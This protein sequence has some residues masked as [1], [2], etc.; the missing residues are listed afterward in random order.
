MGEGQRP[1]PRTLGV[2]VGGLGTIGAVVAQRLDA[3]I[4]GLR[5]AAVAARDRDK[6]RRRIAG[7]RTPVPVVS[8]GELAEV[9]DVVVECVPAKVF[10]EIAAP[11][12]RAG[13]VLVIV[14]TGAML[15]RPD[16]IEVARETG[17]RIIAASGGL[18][19]LD[20]VRAAAEGGIRSARLA[21][22]YPPAKLAGIPFLEDAGV[23]LEGLR[24]PL[25]LFAGSAREAA[26]RFPHVMN[27]AASL[28]LAGTGPGRTA[29]EVWADPGVDRNTHT[30]TVEADSAR[31]ETTIEVAPSGGDALT[32]RIAPLSIIAALR[33]L[34][35]PLTVGG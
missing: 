20:A 10:A 35:A 26:E 5:L 13:R 8:L 17:A 29:V 1:Q 12:V 7:F 16:L 9:A 21:S 31:F 15:A 11:A 18:A 33:G 19:G 25:R 30:V 27:V 22:R 3:G 4:P 32:G 34:V 6:A 28:S 24:Q 14:S 23:S 2:G